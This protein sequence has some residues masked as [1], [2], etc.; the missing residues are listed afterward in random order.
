MQYLGAALAADGRI[1]SELSRKLGAASADFRQLRA[2]WSHAGITLVKKLVYFESMVVSKLQYGLATTWLVTSQRRRVDGFYARCLR[3]ILRI[4]PAFVSRTSNARVFARAAVVPFTQKLLQRQLVLLGKAAHSNADHPLRRDTF[5]RDGCIPLVG[6]FVRRIG[7]P[8]QD[9]TSQVLAE[10]QR[11][12]GCRRCQTLL[13]DRSPGAKKR[14]N[15]EVQRV[16]R[17]SF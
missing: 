11:L 8:R 13:A 6:R 3:Q 15:A 14:W 10:A 7:R 9:W 5:G 16:C 17:T 1:D 12:F 2:L 4:P